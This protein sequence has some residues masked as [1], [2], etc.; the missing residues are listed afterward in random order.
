MGIEYRG[1]NNNNN[2]MPWRRIGRN[3]YYADGREQVVQC[4]QGVG[5]ATERGELDTRPFRFQATILSKLV[6]HTCLG[7]QALEFATGQRAVFC[8]WGGNRRFG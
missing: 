6:I 5:L 8:G 3:F 1:Q 4:I 7:H 2:T